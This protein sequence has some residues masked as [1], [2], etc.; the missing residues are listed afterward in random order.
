[1]KT[2]YILLLCAFATTAHPADFA[3]AF[4]ETGLGTRGLGM[5]TFV[6][7]AAD[8]SSPYWNP[9]GLARLRGKALQTSLQSLSQDRL[10]NSASFALNLRGDMGFGFAWSRASVDKIDGRTASG[11]Y[12][13]PIEDGANAFTVAVGRTLGPRLSIGFAM[14]FFDQTIDLPF[15]PAATANGSGFDLG[16]QFHLAEH[17]YLGAAIRNLGAKLDWKVRLANEQSSATE[18]PLPRA[19]VFGAAHRPFAALLLAAE[20]RSDTEQNAHLGAEWRISPLLTVRGGLQRLGAADGNLLSA[21]LTLRPM[22]VETLQFHYAY[23]ADP[24]E[25]GGRTTVGLALAF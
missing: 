22:R 3:A 1:M 21:G 14:K 10:Q 17:T 2:L 6:A 19:L 7:I 11:Q 13:G 18:D 5:G 25:V 24:L 9:A 15:S 16:A 4:L 12:T 8:A 23:L 20:L